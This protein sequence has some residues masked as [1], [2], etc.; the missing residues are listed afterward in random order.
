MLNQSFEQI[1]CSIH[2]EL[3]VYGRKLLDDLRPFAEELV[4]SK[5]AAKTV[6]RHLTNL[7]LLGGAIIR[8]VSLNDEY[9]T[10]PGKVLL[11][12]VDPLG[13]LYHRHLHS[14]ADEKSYDSTC[15]K[16]YKHLKNC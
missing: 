11:D 3:W 10:P 9:D 4:F 8:D 15:K 13:G 6:K 14:I 1:N 12:V 16:L 7:W 5:L 2:I